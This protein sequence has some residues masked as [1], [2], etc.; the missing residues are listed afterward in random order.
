MSADDQVKQERR[1][2]LE[3]RGRAVVETYEAIK[4]NLGR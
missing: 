2:D 4:R 3:Y 1:S